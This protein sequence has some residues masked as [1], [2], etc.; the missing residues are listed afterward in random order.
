LETTAVL[1][2]LSPAEFTPDLTLLDAVV[3]SLL[4]EPDSTLFG[5]SSP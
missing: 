1:N 3:T 2:Q 4:V 5:D